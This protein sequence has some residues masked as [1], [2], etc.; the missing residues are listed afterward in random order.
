[1][2]LLHLPERLPDCQHETRVTKWSCSTLSCHEHK[3]IERE[4]EREREDACVFF[5][6]VESWHLFMCI[7]ILCV[8]AYA[9]L[10]P[11]SP[12]VSS[13][14]TDTGI[15]QEVLIPN[16]YPIW[17]S[18]Y[19]LR[20]KWFQQKVKSIKW[21]LAILFWLSYLFIVIFLFNLLLSIPSPRI[22]LC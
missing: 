14:S 6:H 21:A 15:P 8:Y 10:Y 18:R 13:S 4:R 5:L 7:Y 16:K 2:R 11:P 1:M 20:S 9:C 12:S 19:I 3:N 17:P 22:C